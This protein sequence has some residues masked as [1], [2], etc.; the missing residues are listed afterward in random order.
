MKLHVN[1]EISKTAVLIANEHQCDQKKC[2]KCFSYTFALCN[3]THKN[4]YV[5]GMPEDV[6]SRRIFTKMA[7]SIYHRI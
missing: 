7:A 5:N 4:D 2:Y 6:A 3:R 1:M